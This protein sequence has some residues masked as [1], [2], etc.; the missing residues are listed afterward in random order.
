MIPEFGGVY[1][2]DTVPKEKGIYIINTDKS[3]QIGSHWTGLYDDL[4]YDSFGRSLGYKNTTEKDPEQEIREM[5]CG[6]RTCTFLIIC[7]YL[8][9]NNAKYI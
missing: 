8:G 6:Q 5:N 1:M 7:Y 2:W 3:N 9:K 4:F